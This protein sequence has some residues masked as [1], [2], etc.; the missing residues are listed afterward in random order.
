MIRLRTFGA[1]ELRRDDREVQ[2]VLAHPRRLA[3]LVY[4][5][6]ARPGELHRRDSLLALLWPE[7]D[8]ERARAALRKAVHMLRQA[9]GEDVIVRRGDD[10]LGVDRALLWCDAAAAGS[11]LAAGELEEAIEWH[12]GPFLDGFHLDDAPDFER[13]A[14]G[15]RAHWRDAVFR[16]ICAVAQTAAAA[17]D[18]FA[19]AAWARRGFA[20]MPHDEQA[21]RFMLGILDR[22]GDRAGAVEAFETFARRLRDEYGDEPAPETRR[23]IEEIRAR[24]R[25]GDAATRAAP[26][27]AARPGPPARRREHRPRPQRAPRRAPMRLRMAAVALAAVV[28]AG[29]IS[30]AAW[31]RLGHG[32]ATP[33]AADAVAVLPFTIRGSPQ[34]EYLAEGMVTL[35]SA[36]L[37]AV[38]EIRS[39]DA[40]AVLRLVEQRG[41]PRDAHEARAIADRLAARYYLLGELVEAGG[42]LRISASLYDRERPGRPQRV[43]VS[44]GA[45][46]LFSLVD[47]LTKR[48]IAGRVT[49][50]ALRLARI[51]ALTTESL[52]ALSAYLRGE[53][54]YR[55]GR[56]H[57]AAD[58][59]R[60]ATEQDST[61]ALAWYRLGAARTWAKLTGG[62]DAALTAQRHSHRLPE[63]DRLLIDAAVL[64][65]DGRAAEAE[66]LYRRVLAAHPDD[67][68]AWYGL[69][70]VLFHSQGMVGGS[71]EAAAG[72]F[73]RVLR[74]DPDNANVLNHMVRIAGA[75]GDLARMRA[76][77][78][79]VADLEADDP[80]LP[81]LAMARGADDPDVRQRLAH[82]DAH[83][84]VQTATS[85]AVFADDLDGGLAA[86][87]A[88]IAPHRDSVQRGTGYVIMAGLELAA[89]RIRGARATLGLARQL[90]PAAALELESLLAAIH[91][92]AH[93]RHDI[94]ALFDAVGSAPEGAAETPLTLGLAGRRALSPPRRQMML[95]LLDARRGDGDGALDRAAALE[96][97]AGD[98]AVR[99]E[100]RGGAV[101]SW[102]VLHAY[103][104][105]RAGRFEGALAQLGSPWPRRYRPTG[106][107][108]PELLERL[109]RA[110][111]HRAL[112]QREEALRW[113]ATFPDASGYDFAFLPFTYLRRAELLDAAGDRVAAARYYARFATLWRDCDPELRP[114]VLRAEARAAALRR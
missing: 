9:L 32:H 23:L 55:T 98:L 56:Y 109:L 72:A 93:A 92:A 44:G 91:P 62:F 37:D 59:F 28:L 3:L 54:E 53:R 65:Y 45:H 41:R 85:L 76:L 87:S 69:G 22:V 101:G 67:V 88:L 80:S 48:V 51:G 34:L 61:F 96:R 57:A 70:D 29:S 58:L 25:I 113:Y 12:R 17:G 16:A 94:D 15:V 5:A 99:P 100:H 46:D 60:S 74:V 84:I 47:Q 102:W 7:H 24:T 78:I 63:S 21:L 27:T 103:L 79:R 77:A 75:A 114:L 83:T 26:A 2:S 64:V 107:S 73:E 4:L 50:P 86:V 81:I 33:P 49:D 30:V 111:V 112:G 42:E 71:L 104:D 66:Q 8:G 31:G 6:A 18:P 40:F 68:E 35:L 89:G 13:W 97:M 43:T 10:E 1:L 106:A 105:W 52:P 108:Y 14:D 90:E 38:G 39:A 95:A 36:N 110:E 19:A 82:A 20:A 11:A